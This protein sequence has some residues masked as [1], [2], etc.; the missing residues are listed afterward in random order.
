[1]KKCAYCNNV[2]NAD[3]EKQRFCSK[4]CLLKFYPLH[5]KF[6]YKVKECPQCKTR[7][8]ISEINQ[9]F[10]SNICKEEFSKEK[11][12]SILIS[13]K[14]CEHCNGKFIKTQPN[15]KFCSTDC[16]NAFFKMRKAVKK[17]VALIE[18]Y[19]R[20]KKIAKQ[21]LQKLKPGEQV[22]LANNNERILL[23]KTVTCLNCNT[24]FETEYHRQKFCSLECNI[25]YRKQL[26]LEKQSAN[27]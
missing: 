11:K 10:C 1:M 19:S 22:I 5:S 4:E 6:K 27:N 3:Y 21:K 9:K 12:E 16:H 18:E 23:P 15:Q 20:S 8:E 26:K 24:I 14:T 17:S 25:T 13:T 7:F 2:F